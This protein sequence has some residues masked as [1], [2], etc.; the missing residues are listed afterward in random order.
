MTTQQKALFLADED[1]KNS[2]D[3]PPVSR[4]VRVRVTFIPD[5]WNL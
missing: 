3:M 5:T 1:T 2:T 4:L